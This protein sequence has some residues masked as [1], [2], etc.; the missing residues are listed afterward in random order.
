MYLNTM[1]FPYT[2]DISTCNE[3]TQESRQPVAFMQGNTWGSELKMMVL[4]NGVK[5]AAS[6]M[7][8]AGAFV[9]NI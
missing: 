9:F 6:A 4:K 3:Y 2:C 1:D 8:A 5:I 7:A